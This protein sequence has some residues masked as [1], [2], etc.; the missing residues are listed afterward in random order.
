M[1]RKGFRVLAGLRSEVLGVHPTS[2]PEEIRSRFLTLTLE[3]HPD[4]CP[5]T[6]TDPERQLFTRRFLR[7]KTAYEVLKN[8][9]SRR[10][11]DARIGVTDGKGGGGSMG[12]NASSDFSAWS[13][14]S[15]VPPFYEQPRQTGWQKW[16]GEVREEKGEEEDDEE[17]EWGGRKR[18]VREKVALKFRRLGRKVFGNSRPRGATLMDEDEGI[19]KDT[20]VVIASVWGVMLMLGGGAWLWYV[21]KVENDP[22]EMARR[23]ASAKA[24]AA[25]WET[26]HAALDGFAW[27]MREHRMKGRTGMWPSS[28]GGGDRGGDGE[29]AAGIKAGMSVG[30]RRESGKGGDYIAEE[31][32]G[33][34]RDASLNLE[35][36]EGG[37]DVGTPIPIQGTRMKEQEAVDEEGHQRLVID[38][39]IV[40]YVN[41][42][43]ERQRRTAEAIAVTGKG[44]M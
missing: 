21:S 42:A 24:A 17:L 3:T 5:P 35:K 4:R 25:M 1:D 43:A 22:A 27:S 15:G 19:T 8:P 39:R 30:K 44:G 16:G 18:T 29:V 38:A 31:E 33:K 40:G 41:M 37:S 28:T 20:L 34:G 36:H 32:G 6:A 23:N 12:V 14:A 2:R 26:P 13:S 10:E 7:A 11:Y 9:V